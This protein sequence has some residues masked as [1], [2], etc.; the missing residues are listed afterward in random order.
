MKV[1]ELIEHLQKYDM[2]QDVI[3][4]FALDNED[5]IG[6]VLIPFGTGLYFKDKCAIY[7]EYTATKEDCDFIGQVDLRE[8]YQKIKEK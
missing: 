3:I 2:E 5:D 8:A 1:K 4:R 7:A 6:Y